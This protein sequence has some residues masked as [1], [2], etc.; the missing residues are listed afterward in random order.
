MKENVLVIGSGGREHAFVRAMRLSPSVASVF[1]APGNAGMASVGS[2]VPLD[3]NDHAA[4]IRFIEEN[5]VALTVIGPEAPLVAG[6][7]DALRAKGFLVLGASQKA[8]QLEGSK[9]HAK[10][11]M[12]KYGLPTAD[13]R[14]FDSAAAAKR[15]AE[16]PEG[17]KF[18]VMKADGLAAGKG[19]VVAET[20]EE[21]V[22]A[23]EEAMEQKRFGS[24][25]ERILLE[26][27]L[28][29][30]EVSIMALTDGRTVLPFPASQDHK[31]ALDDDRGPNTGGM[32]AYAPTPF[33]D[34]H[35]RIQVERDVIQNFV[36]GVQAEGL[37][38]RGI[39]YF[40]LMLTETGPKVLEFN[41]RLG[42]PEAEVVLPL[43][44]SDLYQLFK[45]VAEGRLSDQK[46][47]LHK[48]YACTVVMASGGYPGPFETGYPVMGLEL[49]ERDGRVIVFHAGTKTKDDEVL[50]TGGRV[51]T[52]TGLGKSLE[53]AV[54][55]AYQGVKRISFQK[56]HFRSDI[57]GK[58][59]A[60]RRIF[61]R[62]Q[63]MKGRHPAMV[64]GA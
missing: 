1:C 34:D 32:G 38:Y 28:S 31:R 48:G 57:A 15:F 54:V 29:G 3:V 41:V 30:P 42:D 46:L 2:V 53:L 27:T 9:I 13:F 5:K 52:V 64:G 18:R 37:D 8:A 51:L 17:K 21:L 26:E 25:G 61:R 19:V 16:S 4:V 55:R 44:K 47:E 33:Y 56:A 24:A 39:I 20:Q 49:A 22:T 43:A 62:I 59:L 6:L 12:A 35:T 58:A 10:N 36:R 7:S 60:N 50:T 11:F 40:G 23:I 63:R 14:V 45:A